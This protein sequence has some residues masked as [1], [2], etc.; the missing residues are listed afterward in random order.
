MR[1]NPLIINASL[2]SQDGNLKIDLVAFRGVRFC[3]K[4]RKVLMLLSLCVRLV[5]EKRYAV[6]WVFCVY[7]LCRPRCS[8]CSFSGEP[9]KYHTAHC[10]ASLIVQTLYLLRWRGLLQ[11]VKDTDLDLWMWVNSISS[12]R[13][14][15]DSLQRNVRE[16]PGSSPWRLVAMVP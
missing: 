10:C 14:T 15:T 2:R 8:G 13:R 6:L 4:G 3:I 1:D 5:L 7:S 12:E 11:S 16:T 9:S